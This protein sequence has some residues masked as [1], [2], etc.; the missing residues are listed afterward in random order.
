MFYLRDA[1]VPGYNKLDTLLQKV[2]LIYIWWGI[3]T[4]TA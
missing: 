4:P 1:R 2:E 3:I